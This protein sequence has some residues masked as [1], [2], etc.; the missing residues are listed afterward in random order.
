MITGGTAKLGNLF[1]EKQMDTLERPKLCFADAG[2]E[3]YA[4]EIEAELGEKYVLIEH[5]KAVY[6][7]AVLADIL[8]NYSSLSEAKVALYEKHKKDLKDLK[9][10]VRENL[11]REEYQRLFAKKDEKANYYA[12]IKAPKQCSQEDFYGYLKKNILGKI[13]DVT[14]VSCMQK[15][16]EMGT[17]LPKQTVK[18]NSVIPYQIHLYELNAIL[19]NLEDKVPL[20]K[21]NGEKIQ[22]IFTFRIPYYVGPLNGI[23][24]KGEKSNWAVRKEGKIYPW[25]F[26]EM[27]DLEA[28]AEQ[29]I[30]RMTNKCTYLPSEDVLPKYSLLYSKYEVLN[31]LNNLRLDGEKISVEQKQKIYEEVFQKSRKVTQKK[32]KNYLVKE[33]ITGKEVEIT[34]I[35]GD[36]KSSLTAYHDFK[37]KLT[38]LSLNQAEKECIILNVTLFGDDK[39]IL[40][41]RLKKLFPE[42]TEKQRDSISKL[43]YRGWGRL[44]KV[45]LEETEAPA[46]E[47][48]EAWSIIRA[49]WETNDNLMQLLSEKYL[50]A[51]AIEEKNGYFV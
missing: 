25:N 6:D 7:W 30:R 24:K 35:D 29:F 14:K 17:F 43:P 16:M 4:G 40:K 28:S 8:Q 49:L 44:S 41:Q 11:S 33:G 15:E 20:L 5:A 34:G 47:T 48:G 26:D 51:S 38:N 23:R 27:V 21:E 13:S 36:F 12:Y 18:D 10:L 1:G 2:Y 50:F 45:F 19:K 31:E 22:K 46:P 32:L 3:E 39:A 37:E 42:L 9:K